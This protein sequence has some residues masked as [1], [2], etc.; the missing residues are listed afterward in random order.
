MR[1]KWWF[2]AASIGCAGV[3]DDDTGAPDTDATDTDTD[4]DTDTDDPDGFALVGSYVDTWGTQHTITE[5]LWT[6]T[7][8]NGDGE[9]YHLVGHDNGERWAIARNDADN[10]WNADKYSRFDWVV[11]GGDL[12]YCQ[13]VFDAETADDARNATPADPG[14]RDGGCGGFTWTALTPS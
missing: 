3:V 5:E 4:A 1:S 11:D 10:P 12:W 7:F 13:S 9:R 2:L 14:D 8:P 6:Q